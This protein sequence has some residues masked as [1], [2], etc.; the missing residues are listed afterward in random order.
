MPIVGVEF[1]TSEEEAEDR[2]SV[3]GEG[4]VTEEGNYYREEEVPM[5]AYELLLDFAEDDP[6]A[7]VVK[8]SL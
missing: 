1:D 7:E 8:F 6:E 2:V 4:R 3:A 5:K